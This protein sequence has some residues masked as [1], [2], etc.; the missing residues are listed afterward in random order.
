MKSIW[1]TCL[2]V[3]SL[4]SM[5]FGQDK[6]TTG[7][8]IDSEGKI[9]EGKFGTVTAKKAVFYS[10]ENLRK[11]RTYKPKHIQGFVL[12]QE[13]SQPLK[14]E[15]V[16]FSSVVEPMMYSG[17]IFMGVI[18][19]GE[20]VNLYYLKIGDGEFGVQRVGIDEKP[21][22]M[23]GKRLFWK[24]KGAKFFEDCPSVA[25]KISNGELGVEADDIVKIVEEYEN[26]DK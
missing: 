10:N 11:A 16:K 14:F 1:I 9:I 21:V 22:S 3:T 7:H 13:N 18:S 15:S 4:F 2:L 25:E 6:R 8:I 12:N 19:K 23:D 17:D 5:A 26:C 24:K 20:K